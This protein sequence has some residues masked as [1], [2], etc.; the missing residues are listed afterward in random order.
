MGT[1]L[2]PL[3]YK[4]G[5][6]KQMLKPDMIYPSKQ[7]MEVEL[8]NNAS[9]VSGIEELFKKYSI[10]GWEQ[11][12]AVI[13]KQLEDYDAWITANL[14]PKARTDFRLP[15][16]EYKLALEGYGIDIPPAEIAKMAHAAFTDI[17]NQMKPLAEEVAKKYNLPSA[18]N[19]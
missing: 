8:K 4:T 9:M 1:N 7:Q 11:P 16:D 18:S 19:T 2:L 6:Q 5:L 3:F 10:A 14:L 17:Q 15:P 12:Y 13:K